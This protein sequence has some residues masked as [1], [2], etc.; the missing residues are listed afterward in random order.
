[1]GNEFTLRDEFGILRGEPIQAFSGDP[2]DIPCIETSDA[3]KLCQ[4]PVVSVNMV[5][6]N[7]EPYIRQA[8]E[9]V[10]MQKTDFE[11]EL[12]IGED[13]STDRTREICFEYQK[14]YPDKIRVL[15]CDHNLYRNP[16]PAGGNYERNLAHCRGGFIALCEGDDYWIDPR[17][18]QKQVDVMRNHLNVGLCFCDAIDLV[19]QTGEETGYNR[20]GDIPPDVIDGKEFLRY[21]IF[22]RNGKLGRA[23][24]VRTATTLFRRCVIEEARKRCDILSWVLRLGDVPH[25]LSL[26]SVSDVYFLPDKTAVYRINDG[27]ACARLGSML[28]KDNLLCRIYFLFKC[29]TCEER[30]TADHSFVKYGFFSAV[31]DSNRSQRYIK[32]PLLYLYRLWR[33][34]TVSELVDVHLV[35]WMIK[36]CLVECKMLNP[37]RRLYRMV[38]RHGEFA[39]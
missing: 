13:C 20:D 31:R 16:H 23:S 1:M 10:M 5:T 8:I 4:H 19:Q 6:Y 7:H 15:W 18:L 37:I 21:N 38:L 28:W 9:G 26:A 11:F 30:I 29:F 3:E 12:V 24:F 33:T 36:G 27:G 2:M 34:R 32:S 17:K 25:W 22:G 35:M 39:G 14:R